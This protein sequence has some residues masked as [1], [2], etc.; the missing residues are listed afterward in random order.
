M[1]NEARGGE[2]ET[3]DPG[4]PPSAFGTPPPSPGP[5]AAARKK[6]GVPETR[7]LTEDSVTMNT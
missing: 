2:A 4:K 5:A 3:S 6:R 7:P 1:V